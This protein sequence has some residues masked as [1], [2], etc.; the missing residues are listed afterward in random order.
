MKDKT[1][2]INDADP[3]S[4]RIHAEDPLRECEQTLREVQRL[5]RIGSW[6]YSVSDGQ[7]WWSDELY[8]IYGVDPATDRLS[9][10][11]VIERVH[12][13]DRDIFQQQVVS[14]L[15]HRSDYRI[16]MRDGTVRYIQ[17]EVRVEQDAKGKPV[18]MYG[19]AQ[20]ITERKQA[21]EA[22]RESKRYL[23]MIIETAPT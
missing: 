6:R 15:P 3:I 22:L 5:A 20:D 1:N 23:E 12:S 8:R 19:T 13:E 10:Q 11:L 14:G 4:E 21:D 16:V 7:L 9:P 17:E 2:R 18:R